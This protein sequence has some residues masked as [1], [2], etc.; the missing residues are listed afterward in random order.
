MV[1]RGLRRDNQLRQ[2]LHAASPNV[3][4][5]HAP[6]RRPMAGGEWLV[7]H[8]GRQQHWLGTPRPLQD[9]RQRNRPAKQVRRP[10]VLDAVGPFEPDVPRPLFH[11]AVPQ[12]VGQ[13]NP[14]PA[15]VSDRPRPP[16]DPRDLRRSKLLPTVPRAGQRGHGVEQWK[17]LGEAADR[18]PARSF[19]QPFD[20]QL[21]RLGPHRRNSSVAPHVE[22]LEGGNPVPHEVGQLGLGV[23]GR[24]CAGQQPLAHRRGRDRPPVGSLV[25]PG[26]A[27]SQA[28]SLAGARPRQPGQLPQPCGGS[29]ARHQVRQELSAGGA[30][31]KLPGFS[32]LMHAALAEKPSEDRSG[33]EPPSE[34]PVWQTVRDNA[35]V[36][37]NIS[38]W[39]SSI[40]HYDRVVERRDLCVDSVASVSP[41]SRSPV[42]RRPWPPLSEAGAVPGP[43]FQSLRFHPHVPSTAQHAHRD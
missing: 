1:G 43:W 28:N 36:R 3:A 23:V 30:L 11:A 5:H 15:G 41:L 34:S 7:V 39:R 19:D 35:S 4:R 37:T 20:S 42:G 25:G 29:H 8:V 26:L 2:P 31:R 24:F 6:Q 10:L 40:G 12:Q 21:P 18:E 38:L 16:G 22:R 14:L 32:P 27:D 33:H 13:P 9:P 17:P